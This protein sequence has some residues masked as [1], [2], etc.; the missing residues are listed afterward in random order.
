VA[1]VRGVAA[2]ARFRFQD[3]R[4]NFLLLAAAGWVAFTVLWQPDLGAWKDWDLFIAVGFP[5]TALAAYLARVL[6][7]PRFA[8]GTLAFIVVVHLVRTLPFLAYNAGAF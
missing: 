4:T 5:V 3:P 6:L 1:L 7:P 8:L 2:L